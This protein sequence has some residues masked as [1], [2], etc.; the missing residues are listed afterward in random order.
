MTVIKNI[1]L[2]SLAIIIACASSLAIAASDL[3]TINNTKLPSTAVINHGAC[4]TALPNGMGITPPDGKPHVIPGA[5]VKGVCGAH[6]KDCS[7]DVYM[8]DHCNGNGEVPVAYATF[9]T[10]TGATTITMTDYGRA[11]KYDLR[12]DAPFHI[13]MDGGPAAAPVKK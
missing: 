12:S 1:A 4:S 8:S 3:V 13:I 11:A 6:Q 2:T 10:L 9:N 5:I 7:A